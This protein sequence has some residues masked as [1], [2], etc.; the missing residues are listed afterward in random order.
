VCGLNDRQA[1]V[2]CAVPWEGED[3]FPGGRGGWMMN[4]APAGQMI[5]GQSRDALANVCCDDAGVAGLGLTVRDSACRPMASW[6][7]TLHWKAR[8]AIQGSR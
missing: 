6:G 8:P 2:S 1:M 7:G 5:E 3:P 4:G